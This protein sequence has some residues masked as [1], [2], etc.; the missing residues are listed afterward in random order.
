MS[1]S[2]RQHVAIWE[3]S[4]HQQGNDS[5]KGVVVDRDPVQKTSRREPHPRH[6][7]GRRRLVIHKA[8]RKTRLK[9][10]RVLQA[11]MYFKAGNLAR[12]DAV[13]TRA[14]TDTGSSLKALKLTG[15]RQSTSNLTT[16][17]QEATKY[18]TGP[19]KPIFKNGTIIHSRRNRLFSSCNIEK[20]QRDDTIAVL[21]KKR[22]CI[23]FPTGDE[24]RIVVFIRGQKVPINRKN[25][26]HEIRKPKQHIF[27]NVFRRGNTAQSSKPTSQSGAITSYSL[28]AKTECVKS[29][30]ANSKVLTT[31]K[32]NLRHPT[33]TRLQSSVRYTIGTDEIDAARFPRHDRQ[34]QERDRRRDDHRMVECAA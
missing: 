24:Q 19:T 4:S 9:L 3:A 28:E 31:N 10:R 12:A 33:E 20:Q 7:H 8:L 15:S 6:T 5:E 23:F 18:G 34:G 29:T 30:D 22:T 21:K 16:L 14:G 32:G 17:A 1:G 25:K 26:N 2:P 11:G 13:S 27:D